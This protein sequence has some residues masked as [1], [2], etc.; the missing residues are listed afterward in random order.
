M[1]LWIKLI[2][3]YLCL[4]NLISFFVCIYDKHA[5]KKNRPRIPEKTLFLLSFIGG[6]PLMLITMKIFRHKTLHKRFM[7]GI[8]LII[9]FQIAT[10][11]AVIYLTR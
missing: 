11:F 9:F 3:I 10:V 8:P 2:L 5:A 7:I 6:S 1:S 4:I